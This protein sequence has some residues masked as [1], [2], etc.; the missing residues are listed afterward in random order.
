MEKLGKVVSVL[1]LLFWS[2]SFSLARS[3]D[4]DFEKIDKFDYQLIYIVD[5]IT[6]KSPILINYKNWYIVMSEELLE[7][8]PINSKIFNRTDVYFLTSN[9]D[10]LD[11]RHF[12]FF[13]DYYFKQL[14]FDIDKNNFIQIGA[15]KQNKYR[16]YKFTCPHIRFYL[17][18]MN[19]SMLNYDYCC[20]MDAPKPKPIK[21]KNALN[22]Y[23][24]VVF[25]FCE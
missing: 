13:P 7:S 9:G 21:Q 3:H 22:T 2:V 10:I 18:L 25:P 17:T 19:L 12:K 24:K 16:V 23:Y 5:T 15:D 4:W 11:N 8:C 6:I 20:V 14:S 1:T